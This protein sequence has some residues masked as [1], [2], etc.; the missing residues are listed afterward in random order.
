MAVP[1]KKRGFR[2][3]VVNQQTFYWKVDSYLDIRSGIFPETKIHVEVEWVD[4]RIPIEERSYLNNLTIT[5]KLVAESIFFALNNHWNPA[6]KTDQVF[7]IRYEK[8]EFSLVV[9]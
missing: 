8:N 7:S 9:Y 4:S 5:P 3:I 2:S 6:I 1:E